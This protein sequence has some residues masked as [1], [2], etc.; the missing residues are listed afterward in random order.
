MPVMMG[1]VI[2]CQLLW[3]EL[4]CGSYD[5]RSYCAPV[6][7]GGLLCTS[8]DGRSYCVPVIMGGVIVCQL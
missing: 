2:M 3:E 8:Y 1:G 4:L 7:M 5:G 6:M